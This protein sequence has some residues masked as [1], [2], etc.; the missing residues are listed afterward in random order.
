MLELAQ[1]SCFDARCT[2][3]RED[4]KPNTIPKIPCLL[5]SELPALLS[6]SFGTVSFYE[7][8]IYSH[9]V[10]INFKVIHPPSD[11]HISSGLIKFNFISA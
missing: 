3:I 2:I 6:T 9:V 1:F 5:F 8:G 10:E 7:N 4:L 11:D